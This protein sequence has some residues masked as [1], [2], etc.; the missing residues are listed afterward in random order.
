MI[1]AS[2]HPIRRGFGVGLLTTAVAF[3]VLLITPDTAEWQSVL[4]VSVIIAVLAAGCVTTIVLLVR[5]RSR[6]YGVAMLLGLAVGL[7]MTLLFVLWALA[8][9]FD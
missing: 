9:S 6:R 7:L 4:D 5:Q 3:V 1:D 8:V 2:V